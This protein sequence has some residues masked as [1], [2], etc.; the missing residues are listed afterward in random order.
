MKIFKTITFGMMCLFGLTVLAVEP[1]ETLESSSV[2]E[3]AVNE[4]PCSTA[5]TVCDNAND[6]LSI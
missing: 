3:T 5:F 2:E 6:R 1:N 4:V